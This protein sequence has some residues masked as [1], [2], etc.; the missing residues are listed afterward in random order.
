MQKSPIYSQKSCPFHEKFLQ[1]I[2]NEELIIPDLVCQNKQT[3]KVIQH[4][5]WNTAAGPDFLH[6]TLLINN[7]L[8]RGDIEIH[9]KTSDWF[10]HGHQNNPN[11]HHVIL[12]VVWHDDMPDQPQLPPALELSRH[13]IPAWQ[14]FFT[15][16]EEYNYSYARK[17][18]PGACSMRWIITENDKLTKL[19]EQASFSRLIQKSHKLQRISA[20]KGWDQTIYEG[21]FD[22]LGYQR[23]RLNCKALAQSL[24]LSIL[25]TIPFA[26]RVSALFLGFAGL[27]PDITNQQMQV[28]PT[29]GVFLRQAW[30]FWWESNQKKLPIT[31]DMTGCR[32]YNHPIR[33]IAAGFSWLKNIEYRPLDWLIKIFTEAQTTK[34]LI[35]F[36]NSAFTASPFWYSTYNFYKTIPPAALLGQSRM[37]D[38]LSNVFIPSAYLIF[39]SQEKKDFIYHLYKNLPAGQTNHLVKEAIHRFLIPPTRSKEILKKNYLQQGLLELYQKFC[40]ALNNDCRNCPFYASQQQNIK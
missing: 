39:S 16:A 14:A 11:Y 19:L 4:G 38:M 27:L 36:I 35:E 34:D 31:W 26:P 12:H 3:V 8:Q 17:I 6:A 20:Q 24:P 25:Q 32:P 15:E 18:Y 7:K 21:V 13:L 10:Q 30:G 29:S 37:L 5:T 9:C 28:P 2:W 40:L 23:N 1:I 33:R 22:A